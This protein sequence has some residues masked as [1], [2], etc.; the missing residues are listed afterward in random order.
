MNYSF[1]K[2]Y[3]LLP[4]SP[5]IHFQ[6]YQKGATLRATEVKPK[7]DKYI[8]KRY[9]KQEGK[10]IPDEWKN[11]KSPNALNY[12]LKIVCENPQIVELGRKTNY[13]IFYANMGN[14]SDGKK[15]YEDF[16][17][18]IFANNKLTVI[19][20]IPD[21]LKFINKIIGDFFVVSNF[22]T[23]QDKGF[24]CYLVKDRKHTPSQIAELLTD[25]YGASTCYS[26]EVEKKEQIFKDIKKIHEILKSGKT[27][28]KS[29]S[30]K[31]ISPNVSSLLYKYMSETY[32]IKNEKEW[33]KRNSSQN[34]AFYVRAFM[35][36]SDHMGNVSI[37]STKTASE[38]KIE[39]VP[40]PIWFVV[41]ENTLYFVA[42][43]IPENLYGAKFNFS[44]KDYK[45]NS[46]TLKVP[47]K[48][49]VGE[50]FIDKFLEYAVA[51]I[52]PPKNY[53]KLK[54]RVMEVE[55]YGKK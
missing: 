51:E 39:R 11:K 29:K 41:Y 25:E 4:Q 45:L 35:G 1:C 15:T 40:S 36:I 52:N 27:G 23:M 3:T 43:R 26:F 42:R 19:C 37:S 14:K 46:G 7:L 31:L 44:S 8:I 16:K 49:T 28:K 9:L 24:G 50:D 30:G 53:G 18:G 5:I 48:E 10:P 17:K 13:D 47:D 21:L 12:K 55:E 6:H 54:I 34:K 33:L 38:I 20:H 2:E 32:K 22:G